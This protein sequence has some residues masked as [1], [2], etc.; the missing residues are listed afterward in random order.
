MGWKLLPQWKNITEQWI[1]LK[2]LNESNLVK[3]S[4]FESARW[5]ESETNF[6]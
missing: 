4:E 1:P 2:Y 3:V 6:I 5:I